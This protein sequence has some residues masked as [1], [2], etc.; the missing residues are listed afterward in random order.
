MP[1]VRTSS[2]APD[3]EQVSPEEKLLKV[4]QGDGEAP[5][6]G[7]PEERLLNSVQGEEPVAEAASGGA[8]TESVETD[9]EAVTE[10]AAAEPAPV[11]AEPAVEAA[12]AA[13]SKLKIAEPAPTVAA[14]DAE[15]AAP[16]VEPEAEPVAAAAASS[17]PPLGA[18]SA[19][20]A[21]GAVTMAS[22]GPLRK[23]EHRSVGLGVVN[24]GLAAA[25]FLMICLTG[26]AMWGSIRDAMVQESGG[27]GGHE[28]TGPAENGAV[29]PVDAGITD[30]SEL[31][32]IED[33]V[34]KYVNTRII[35]VEAERATPTNTPP[36]P[37]PPPSVPQE[38]W[39]QYARKNFKLLGISRISG[40]EVEGIISDESIPKMLYLQVGHE[41][42]VQ[43]VKVAVA[44]V[45]GDGIE[46]TDG[47][48]TVTI[49]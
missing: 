29:P 34:T 48:K 5:E 21:V 24:W 18:E 6:A 15:P 47:K 8:Q 33:V 40:D 45:G 3:D 37:Q 44:R 12:P 38:P 19:D 39:E 22:G 41:V 49:K 27:P 25:I 23:S 43:K 42:K 16:A 9:F 7:T 35:M 10:P 31:Y 30:S 13:P 14:S 2:P 26:H 46:L 20:G 1:K 32:D 17:A 4:I 28:T 36:G 11:A